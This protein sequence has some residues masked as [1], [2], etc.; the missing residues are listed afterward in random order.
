MILLTVI[1]ERLAMVADDDHRRSIGELLPVEGVEEP[2]DLRV[3]KRNLA[4]VLV[5]ISRSKRF[6]RIVREMRIVEMH[7]QQ[8]FRVIHL[9][10][11]LDRIRNHAV[12]AP[13]P[14]RPVLAGL[15][16]T[17]VAIE[18]LGQTPVR[19]QHDRSDKRPRH[20]IMVPQNFSERREVRRRSPLR[21]DG[22]LISQLVYPSESPLPD[23]AP[24][25]SIAVTY[26]PGK[27]AILGKPVS[28]LVLFAGL[29]TV[30]VFA[31]RKRLG[32]AI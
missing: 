11:P 20:K 12:G 21:T 15:G 32:V 9:V 8:E 19:V 24:L 3:G 14:G 16:N 31:L 29:S 10:K 25:E 13:L 23:E 5:K 18:A 7:P 17:D 2:P 27:V 26:P 1:A 28:W 22:K 4:D 30:F 6:W